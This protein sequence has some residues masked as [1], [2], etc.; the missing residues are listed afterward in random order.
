MFY[1]LTPRGPVGYTKTSHTSNRGSLK[2][3]A[4]NLAKRDGLPTGTVKV[5]GV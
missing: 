2:L 4:R 1:V 5:V 3:V